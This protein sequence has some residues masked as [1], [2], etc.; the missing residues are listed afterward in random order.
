MSS[1]TMLPRTGRLSLI[2]ASLPCLSGN[3]HALAPV[4]WDGEAGDL[5]WFS[6]DNW[7][8]NGVPGEMDTVTIDS[9]GRVTAA[10]MPIE[11]ISVEALSGLELIS[12]SL[13]VAT[14]SMIT[15]FYLGGCCTTPLDSGGGTI[16]YLGNHE[17]DKAPT[18]IGS[19]VIEGTAVF[20]DNL[21][22]DDLASLTI[23]AQATINGATAQQWPGASASI[24]GTLNLNNAS[25]GGFF[26]NPDATWYFDGGNLSYTGTQDA[27]ISDKVFVT[28][29]TVSADTKQMEFSEEFV[30]QDTEVVVSNGGRIVFDAGM[31]GLGGEFLGV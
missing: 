27:V 24:T 25:L 15:D 1:R 21:F 28:A 9:G 20:N 23:N 8:P 29:G 18:F 5:L 10:S 14:D 7:N 11:V 12:S 31:P 30:F 3:A 6:D 16:T 19:H 2:I 22:I 4:N 17:F 26:N 13:K